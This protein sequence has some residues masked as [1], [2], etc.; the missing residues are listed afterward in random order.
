MKEYTEADIQAAIDAVLEGTSI[1]QAALSHGVPRQ[2]LSRRILNR[3]PPLLAHEKQQRLSQVQEEN[4][5]KWVL[6]QEALGYA[7]SHGQVRLIA[8]KVLLHQGD[9]EPLGKNWFQGFFRRHPEI[10]TKIGV[11]ID[12]KRIEGATPENINKF[13][14]RLA[15]VS[16]IPPERIYNTDEAGIMEGMGINGLVIGSA[17]IKK[18][19]VYVKSNQSRVWTTFVECISATGNA[20][21]P[22]IIFKGTYVQKQ[23]FAKDFEHPWHFA[24]SENGW[25]SNAIA[26]EW[27]EKVFLPQTQPE[28]PS[29]MR[30]L[31]VNGHGSHTTDEFMWECY[32]NNVY[33]LFLP[34][35]TS[36][37]LQPLDLAIFSVLK[38]IYRR[39]INLLASQTDSAP[40]GKLNFLRCYA[41]AHQEALNINNIKAGFR[42]SGIWP[43]NRHKELKSS[44][45]VVPTRPKTP[46]QPPELA[47]IQ[48]PRKGMEILEFARNMS[49]GTRLGLRKAARIFDTLV[50]ESALQKQR[51]QALEDEVRDLQPKKRQRVIPNPN[52]R[53]VTIDQIMAGAK[54]DIPVEEPEEEEVVDVV[55]LVEP[56]RR[57]T[58]LRRSTKKAEEADDY[59]SE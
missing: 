23:W 59:E 11:R 30:L 20:L 18:H 47:G 12:H 2:T 58:R 28:D 17:E 21:T 35:H 25:T 3:M 44:Q 10:K 54:E 22:A 50:V 14:D 39:H 7:P 16:H 42:A 43:T 26:L 32:R 13:F 6:T 40:V 4:I 36:H 41:K 9:P 37:V 38:T 48:T 29:D 15:T 53:F 33:L 1:R 5:A 52:E 24:C 56:L 34:A 19:R 55:A 45:V 31:I 57:S 46:P 51:I 49:P 8:T 27:L